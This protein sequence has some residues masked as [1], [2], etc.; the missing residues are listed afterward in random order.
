[1]NICNRYCQTPFHRACSNPKIGFDI[2]QTLIEFT[3]AVDAEYLRHR[4]RPIVL[5]HI[6]HTA[7]AQHEC[8]LA[9]NN[10]SFPSDIVEKIL[11]FSPLHE[12]CWSP[13]VQAECAKED[14]F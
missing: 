7:K 4:V 10:E 11:A 12:F 9:L 5:M 3:A 14:E 6:C 13:E 1:M 8:L 2:I